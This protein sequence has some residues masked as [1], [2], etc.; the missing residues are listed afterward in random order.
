MFVEVGKSDT[1]PPFNQ[2]LELLLAKD[3]YLAFAPNTAE[4]RMMISILSLKFP[5][6]R[7]NSVIYLLL[8]FHQYSFLEGCVRYDGKWFSW[9]FLKMFLRKISEFLTYFLVFSMQT[10]NIFLKAYV[11]NLDK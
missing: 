3:E 6:L 8:I 7:V 5:V 9:I 10:N 2:V 1:S 11:Y 4:T